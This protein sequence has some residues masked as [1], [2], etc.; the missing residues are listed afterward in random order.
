MPPSARLLP[1]EPRG[2]RELLA[3]MMAVEAHEEEDE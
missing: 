1:R 3:V 2:A